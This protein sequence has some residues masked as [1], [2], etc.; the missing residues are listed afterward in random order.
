MLADDKKARLTIPT[1]S[2]TKT[3]E[4]IYATATEIIGT[5]GYEIK[6]ACR[7]SPLW[8]RRLEAKNQ[9]SPEGVSQLTEVLNDRSWMNKIYNKVQ[10][11]KALETA[12]Q[13]LTPLTTRLKRQAEA[14]RINCLF[15]K[16]QSKVYS[17]LQG[18]NNKRADPPRAKT[19]QYWKNIWEKEM[20]YTTSVKW[21]VDLRADQ[22]TSQKKRQ[23]TLWTWGDPH[24]PSEDANSTN[25]CAHNS[26]YSPRLTNTG[27]RTPPLSYQL[28]TCVYTTWKL[29]PGIIPT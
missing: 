22:A 9:G 24:L 7:E 25:K 5:L 10:I 2:V 26:R 1:T 27:Q 11:T 8:R 18:N 3:N 28:I 29:V 19:E 15:S 21:L 23:S 14:K 20:L 6:N 4:L 12:E 16:D 17:Q 13:K